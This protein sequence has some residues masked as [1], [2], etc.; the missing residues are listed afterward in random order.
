[1]ESKSLIIGLEYSAGNIKE[2]LTLDVLKK[3]SPKSHFIITETMK[4]VIQV[5][6]L[7][8]V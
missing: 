8:S 1:M 3:T 2:K 6:Y 4:H 5:W 7:A